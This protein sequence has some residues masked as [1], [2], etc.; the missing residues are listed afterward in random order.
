M[1]PNPFFADVCTTPFEVV[2]SQTVS[3]LHEEVVRQV[4]SAVEDLGE[5]DAGAHTGKPLLLLTAPRA[6]YGK[7]HVLGRVA[8]VA[9]T[10]ALA[11]PLIFRSDAEVSWSAASLEAMDVL[12]RLP[13]RTP[14]WSRLREVCAGVLAGFM[15][16]LIQGGRLPC[17]NPEQA[18]RVLGGDPTELFRES[19]T[20]RLIGDW[21]RRHFGQLRKPLS[22]AASELPGAGVMESWV[23][24]LFAY[25]NHGT[26]ATADTVVGL[27]TGSRAAFQLWLRL[28]TTWRPVVLMVDHLDGFYRHEQAGLRIATILLDLADI[29]GVHV[30]LSLNQD[31]W[32]ATFA[33]HLPSAVEDRLT[34]SQFL[35]RGLTAE[36]ASDLIRLRLKA[37]GCEHEAVHFLAFMDVPRHFQGRPLGSVSA[38]AFLRH[39]AQQ[40]AIYQRTDAGQQTQVVENAPIVAEKQAPDT[41][42]SLLD[43]ESSDEEESDATET[44]P[45]VSIFSGTDT[46]QMQKA[47][48]GLTEPRHAM[49]D[50]PFSLVPSLAAAGASLAAMS[51]P[52]L[53]M[54]AAP[55]ASPFTEAAPPPPRAP[56]T[57]PQAPGAMEH[58]RDMVEK[59]RATHPVQLVPAPEEALPPP[60]HVAEAATSFNTER[61]ATAASAPV[62]S[63]PSAEALQSRFEGLRQMMGREAQLHPLDHA[64]LGE[65][66]RLA[67]KRFPLV[68]QDEI[69]LMQ[70]PG[71]KVLRWTVQNLEI[72]FGLADLGDTQYW[73]TLSINACARANEL[74]GL[75]LK[76]HEAP[77]QVKL[78]TFKSDMEALAWTSIIASDVFPAALRP[79]IEALHL[80]LRSIA[81]LYAMHRIIGEAESGSLSAT[82]SQVMSV[83]ARELDFFWKRVTRPLGNAAA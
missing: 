58:L 24:A 83:L 42:P 81:S 17:A 64:K 57:Q 60:T 29:D 68:K 63:N 13:G 59:L 61:P 35:L 23:D 27:A 82:P 32:Q 25:A 65:L 77:P 44:E 39:A 33:H 21:L 5:R 74:Q 14:G 52:F 38:R 22:L 73:R 6:G 47:A 30:V 34:A 46:E 70:L 56:E 80:D 79:N 72:L 10:Q 55:I 4:A 54:S 36:D 11:M 53:A 40:W 43:L 18:I 26:Q 69:D 8:A 76:P 37:A 41:I 20:A 19:S 28:V 71:R 48:E 9:D 75:P 2:A 16:K 62:R 7:T 50:T 3:A 45:E 31:V 15:Q 66:I 51:S 1:I 49:V 12:R 78:V 67:G